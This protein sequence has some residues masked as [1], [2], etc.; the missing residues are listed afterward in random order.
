MKF[1]SPEEDIT[2]KSIQ[3]EAI[4]ARPREEEEE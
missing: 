1:A 3:N 2:W 4:S